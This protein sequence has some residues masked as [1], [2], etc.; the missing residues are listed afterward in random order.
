[1]HNLF[2]GIAKHVLKNIWLDS[3]KPLVVKKDLLKIQDGM[4]PKKI[5]NSFGGFT[6]EQWKSF[7]VVLSIYALFNILP[8]TDWDFVMACAFLCSPV[9]AE[10]IAILAHSHPLNFRKCFEE[11]YGKDKVTLNMHLHTHPLDCVLGY[12]PVYA[13]WL[14]S[15]EHHNGIPGDYRTNQH[16]V[17]GKVSFKSS[18]KRHPSPACVY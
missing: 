13:F 5:R 14:F 16:A 8:K 1:M 9:L 12:G 7:T 10:A 17:D 15:F 18:N 6:A 4:M 2:I 11:I 3:D